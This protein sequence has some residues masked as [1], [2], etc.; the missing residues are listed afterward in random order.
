MFF[1]EVTPD[2][3]GYMIAG[4]AITFLI[5]AIYVA[6]IYVRNRNLKQD[7]QMLAELERAV[8]AEEKPKKKTARGVTKK[9]AKK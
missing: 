1:Q 7:L 9:G 3:T 4:F 5:L 2:T 8:P 6:S